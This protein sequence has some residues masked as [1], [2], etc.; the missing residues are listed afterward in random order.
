MLI[1]GGSYDPVS[2][3]SH[4][5]KKCRKG[6]LGKRGLGMLVPFAPT[7]RPVHCSVMVPDS[8]RKQQSP[9]AAKSSTAAETSMYYM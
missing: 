9:A 1:K 7:L 8:D 5:R 6:R 3:R 2:E 4:R